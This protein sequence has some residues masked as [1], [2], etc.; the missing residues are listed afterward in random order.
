MMM[1]CCGVCCIGG[2]KIFSRFT[3]FWSEIDGEREKGSSIINLSVYH[4]YQPRSAQWEETFFPKTGNHK[5]NILVIFL[6]FFKCL[7]P[8]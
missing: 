6:P 1:M 4:F 3:D 7:A 2:D 5:G 8:F